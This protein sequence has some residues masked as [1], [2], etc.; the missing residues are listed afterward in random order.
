MAKSIYSEIKS[1]TGVELPLQ[2]PVPT[3]FLSVLCYQKISFP[4][5]KYLIEVSPH[6]PVQTSA[7]VQGLPYPQNIQNVTQIS[8]Y[9][10]EGAGEE[11]TP[12]PAYAF[13][14]PQLALTSQG[15]GECCPVI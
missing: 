9:T 10:G 1:K 3:P 4:I 5:F 14:W 15:L 12:P 2:D 6:L 7:M 11:P 8:M 13:A